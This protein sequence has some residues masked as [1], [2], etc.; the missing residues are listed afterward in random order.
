MSY[1]SYN[2]LVYLARLQPKRRKTYTLQSKHYDNLNL[3]LMKDNFAL[4]TK[5]KSTL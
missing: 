4:K 3:A 1:Y 5:N 2:Y